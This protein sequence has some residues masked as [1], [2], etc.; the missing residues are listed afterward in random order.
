AYVVSLIVLLAGV[1]SIFYGFDYGV[2]FAGGRSYTVKLDK[3]HEVSNVREK[4]NGYFGEYPIVKTI[5]TD[6]QLN[7]TTAYLIDKQ[8]PETEQQ[9]QQKL[10]EGLTKEG[11][12]PAGTSV[13]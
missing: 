7:I 12:I 4:L 8:G 1:S 5:G 9:V 10:Y 3:E 13:D 6:N 2:E 11:F